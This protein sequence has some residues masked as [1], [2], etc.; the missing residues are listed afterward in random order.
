HA[1]RNFP[2]KI[3]GPGIDRDQT[4][5]RR[6][7]ARQVCNGLA[8]SILQ[9]RGES[10]RRHAVVR[11]LRGFAAWRVLRILLHPARD[12]SV[13]RRKKDVLQI[14]ID[15]RATPAWAAADAGKDEAGW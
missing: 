14:R 15:S 7:E 5:P 10:S 2:G 11:K 1:Q 6:L 9:G 8:C 12:R 4:R 3:A 13:F